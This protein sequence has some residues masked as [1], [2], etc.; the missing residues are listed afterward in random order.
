MPIGSPWQTSSSAASSTSSFLISA[1]SLSAA[2]LALPA[3]MALALW[4]SSSVSGVAMTRPLVLVTLA[5]DFFFRGARSSSSELTGGEELA[6]VTEEESEGEESCLR[7]LDLAMVGFLFAVDVVR[8]R[9]D[10]G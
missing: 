9:S 4:M 8:N 7:F 10:K 5:L 6:R 3:A 2:Y 1:A